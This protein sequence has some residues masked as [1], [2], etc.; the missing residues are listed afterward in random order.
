MLVLYSIECKSNKLLFGLGICSIELRRQK[1]RISR[2]LF[3]YNKTCSNDIHPGE[4]PFSQENGFRVFFRLISKGLEETIHDSSCDCQ[5]LKKKKNLS[6][7][8]SPS[9][10]N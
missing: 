7:S 6:L 10:W 2:S 1:L 5:P 3:V 9:S 8:L 4:T